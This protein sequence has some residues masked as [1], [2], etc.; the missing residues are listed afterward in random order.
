MEYIEQNEEEQLNS[1]DSNDSEIE[2][3]GVVGVGTK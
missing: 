2:G 3:M 1:D